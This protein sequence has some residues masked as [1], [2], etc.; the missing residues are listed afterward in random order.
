M[1]RGRKTGGR[2]KGTRNKR[3][4]ARFEVQ[5]REGVDATSPALAEMRRCADKM[6]GLADE[7]EKKGKQADPKLI[8]EY[9]DS[10]AKILREICQYETPKLTPIR[11]VNGLENAIPSDIRSLTNEQLS[12]LLDRLEQ[13]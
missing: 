11:I 8:K 4:L 9:L 1:A 7:E 10:S 2:Q 3:T 13:S 12:V 6:L 5:R